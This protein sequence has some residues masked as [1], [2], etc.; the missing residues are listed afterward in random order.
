MYQ[1]LEYFMYQLT[2]ASQIRRRKEGSVVLIQDGNHSTQGATLTMFFDVGAHEL[3]LVMGLF[4]LR[5]EEENL[6][7]SYLEL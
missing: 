1:G 7:K 2:R 3:M 5:E 6:W 4:I